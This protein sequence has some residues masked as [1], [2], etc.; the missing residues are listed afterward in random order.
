MTRVGQGKLCQLSAGSEEQPGPLTISLL[1]ARLSV[2]LAS[3]FSQPFDVSSWEEGAWQ[4]MT[5][6]VGSGAEAR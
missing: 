1:F 2:Q 6:W 3:S 5:I 4:R